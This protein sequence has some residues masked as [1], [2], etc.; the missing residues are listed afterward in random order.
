MTTD[1]TE[2]A[3]RTANA[4]AW[5]ARIWANPGPP[6]RWSPADEVEGDW[7]GWARAGSDRVADRW[8]GEAPR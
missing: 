1:A 7:P 5:S 8:T 4:E 3:T 6:P 2:A